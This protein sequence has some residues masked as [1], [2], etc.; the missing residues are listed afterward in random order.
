MSI[1]YHVLTCFTIES[2]LILLQLLLSVFEDVYCSADIG[3]VYAADCTPLNTFTVHLAN[4]VCGLRDSVDLMDFQKSDNTGSSGVSSASDGKKTALSTADPKDAESSIRQMDNEIRRSLNAD[5]LVLSLQLI[6]TVL[7][8]LSESRQQAQNLKNILARDTQLVQY[9]SN[10]IR[11]HHVG[12]RVKRNTNYAKEAVF[13]V[14]GSA[15]EESVKNIVK[16]TLQLLGNVVHDC[17][18]AQVSREY[19]CT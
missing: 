17:S 1:A 15:A 2:Q 3:A 13:G 11:D 8:V 4:M 5:F 10:L 6:G 7:S 12:A 19:F 18:E 14:T 16:S 9:C